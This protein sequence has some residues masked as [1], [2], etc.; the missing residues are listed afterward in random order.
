[1]WLRCKDKSVVDTTSNARVYARQF[2]DAH[3]YTVRDVEVKQSNGQ[4]SVL[5]DGYE[6]L[7]DAQAALDEMLAGVEVLGLE[8]PP[9]PE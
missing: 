4:V 7:E 1:M 6:T 2:G 5:M 8:A 3:G 9:A